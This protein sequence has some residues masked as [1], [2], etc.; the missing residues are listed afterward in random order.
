M[1]PFKYTIYTGCIYKITLHKKDTALL[2]GL[3]DYFSN[4]FPNVSFN[5]YNSRTNKGISITKE[6]VSLTI[7]NIKDIGNIV[8]PFFDKYPVLGVKK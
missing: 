7:T 2:K 8:I 6:T 1:T 5:K 4:Y 3:F